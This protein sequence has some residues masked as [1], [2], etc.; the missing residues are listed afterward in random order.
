MRVGVLVSGSGSNLQSMIDAERRG[1][2]AP[3]KLVCV[4]S[5]RPGVRALERATTAGLPTFVLDHK[6]FATRAEFEARLVAILRGQNVELVA[7]AGFMR[8]LEKTFLDAFP[9][10]VINIHPALLP[11]FPGV[12]GQGQALAYGVKISGCTVHFVDEGTD[13]GPIIAQRAVEVR[14]DDTHDTL[15]E[16]I[17]QEEHALYPRVL[18][19]LAAGKFRVEGRK[20]VELPA[21]IRD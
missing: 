20:V 21:I 8:V 9:G 12:D 18:Q 5:S 1:E 3:A 6:T 14:P 19:K 10:R 4:I 7:L 16:R 15:R 17:L 13:T 11:A 2:L